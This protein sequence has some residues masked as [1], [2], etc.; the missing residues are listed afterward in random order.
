LKKILNCGRDEKGRFISKEQ[1][2]T[3]YWDFK[4]YAIAN[5][6]SIKSL[7]QDLANNGYKTSRFGFKSIHKKGIYS[8]KSKIKSPRKSPR[9]SRR[10]YPRKS[11]RRSTKKSPRKSRRRSTRKS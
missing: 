10:R 4:Q 9:K 2:Y 7:S 11:K 1:G 8:H 5:N 6:G 3:E